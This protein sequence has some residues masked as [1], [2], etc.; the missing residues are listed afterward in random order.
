MLTYLLQRCSPL[1]FSPLE[2]CFTPMHILHILLNCL[3]N[4]YFENLIENYSFEYFLKEKCTETNNMFEIYSKGEDRRR[5]TEKSV[6]VFTQT[7]SGVGLN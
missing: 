1:P 4:L 3:C 2:Y 5:E 6:R 7:N